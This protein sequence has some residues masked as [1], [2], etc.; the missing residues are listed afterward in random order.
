METYQLEIH[1][2]QKVW[3]VETHEIKANS[4]EQAKDKLVQAIIDEDTGETMQ[5]TDVYKNG[6]NDVELNE[7]PYGEHTIELV[8]NGHIEWRNER[9]D[10]QYGLLETIADIAMIAGE[11][12]FYD[13]QHG[14]RGVIGEIIRR[15]QEFENKNRRVEWGYD[16]DYLE[17]I[18]DFANEHFPAGYPKDFSIVHVCID[19]DEMRSILCRVVKGEHW[20]GWAIPYFTKEELVNH[21]EMQGGDGDLTLT[22]REDHTA[23]IQENSTGA[24]EPV[25]IE[26]KAYRHINGGR[27]LHLY[28]MKDLGWT[29]KVS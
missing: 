2:L 26:R 27:T 4:F 5:E 8:Y 15:A 6:F 22:F 1:K 25:T 10:L 17:E 18:I 19:Q 12:K 21:I 9:K 24:E 20:N 3:T 14:S 13:E 7:V 28:C 29:Y 23:V 11:N 16:R